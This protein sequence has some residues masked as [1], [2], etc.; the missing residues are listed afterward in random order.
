M[1][2]M[3]FKND[4]ILL[5]SPAT[6]LNI[7]VQVVVPSFPALLAN[8]SIE[9]GCDEG[10]VLGPVLL[11]QHDYLLIFLLRPRSLNQVG[12]ED[13]LPPMEALDVRAIF[14]VLGNLL[15]ALGSK[16]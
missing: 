1:L 4:F 8:A 11:N 3:G 2:I 6:I 15:P 16:F 5:F 14:K 12:V 10:P 7:R 9:L 13:L